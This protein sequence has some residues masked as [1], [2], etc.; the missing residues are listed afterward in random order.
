MDM[1]EQPGTRVHL[2]CNSMMSPPCL[3]FSG[4]RLLLLH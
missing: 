1:S 2:V 3:E 4:D